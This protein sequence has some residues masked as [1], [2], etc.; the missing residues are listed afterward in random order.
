MLFMPFAL[1]VPAL[2]AALPDHID[3]K[4]GGTEPW[5]FIVRGPGDPFEHPPFA[6]SS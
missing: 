2:V 6:P 4:A 5:S 3:S 1:L